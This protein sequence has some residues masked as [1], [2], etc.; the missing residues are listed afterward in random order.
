MP[1]TQRHKKKKST[2]TISKTPSLHQPTSPKTQHPNKRTV[3]SP[4]RCRKTRETKIRDWSNPSEKKKEK[5]ETFGK[6]KKMKL[7][8]YALRTF[9]GM[10]PQW[11]PS[12]VALRQRP[13]DDDGVGRRRRSVN[14][15]G[16]GEEEVTRADRE[17]RKKKRSDPFL[18]STFLN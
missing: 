12:T 1:H 15:N 13:L 17:F 16:R 3:T 11:C 14:T 2:K 8:K 10:L 6:V 9:Y 7:A 4:H 18:F 5:D